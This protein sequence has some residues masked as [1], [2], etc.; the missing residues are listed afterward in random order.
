MAE[1][2]NVNIDFHKMVED[3]EKDRASGKLYEQVHGMKKEEYTELVRVTND[4]FRKNLRVC[5]KGSSG[6]ATVEHEWG[7]M[8]MTQGAYAHVMS[9]KNEEGDIDMENIYDFLQTLKDFDDFKKEENDFWGEHDAGA[10]DYEN[11]NGETE[12]IFWK[13]DYFDNEMKFHSEEKAFPNRCIR[14]LTVM[15]LS[16]F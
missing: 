11:R 12:R 10:F 7:Y 2:D 5:S 1:D 8:T 6:G 3:L 13:I 9:S 16:E 4:E 14:V 15:L